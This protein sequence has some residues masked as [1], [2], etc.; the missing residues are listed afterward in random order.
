MKD[1]SSS[2]KTWSLKLFID[3]DERLYLVQVE[4]KESLGITAHYILVCNITNRYS[5]CIMHNEI[6]ILLQDNK[7]EP[8]LI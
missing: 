1:T 6:V 3:L 2:R 7:E 4:F 5:D 8:R